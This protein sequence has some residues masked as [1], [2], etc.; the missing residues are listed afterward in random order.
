MSNQDL[1]IGNRY[2][3]DT[4]VD[5]MSLM[6]RGLG[7]EGTPDE[8]PKFKN[9]LDRPS[10][11]FPQRLPTTLGPVTR[12]FTGG[13][14]RPLDLGTLLYY[15]YGFS[16]VDV[17]A[18]NGWPYHR[19]VPSARCFY[20]T[21]LYVVTGDGVHHYDQLH[22]ALV[23]LRGGDHR[24]IV[25]RA[26]GAD[27]SGA[28]AVIVLT[29]HFWKT[30]FRYRHYAYRLC[31]Q[32]AG[33]VAGNVLMVA[34]A[35]GLTGHVHYQFLDAALDHLLGLV[36]GEERTVAVIPLYP[37]GSV[38]GARQEPV[39]AA[40][41][42]AALPEIRP[43]F[44]DVGKDTTLAG[45]VYLVDGHSVLDSAAE[46]G[47]PP[48]DRPRPSGG[49]PVALPPAGAEPDL[50]DALRRRHSGGSL[51][52]PRGESIP[53]SSLTRLARHL[54]QPYSAD[55]GGAPLGEV[56]LAVQR[57]EGLR[58]GVYRLNADGSGPCPVGPLP[59]G[60]LDASMMLGP[61][62]VDVP[63]VNVW[64]YVVTDRERV[65]GAWGNRGYRMAN[66]DAGVVAQR[67]CLLAG[68][69]GLAARPINGYVTADVQRL[70]GIGEAARTPIFQIALGRRT[71]TAQYEMP[72]VF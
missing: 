59:E 33:M 12:A 53:A 71:S 18:I 1:A 24:E 17:G 26:A 4:F 20:P 55:L 28:E 51:F 58:P 9:Y 13:P 70:L 66:M 27:L 35:L 46:F 41:L 40:E 39:T 11:P 61:P 31:T 29:S 34:A 8:P 65:T 21:E 43:P 60:R 30:A 37:A 64:C 10:R 44:T 72:V 56:Y 47:A 67:L 69:E 23:E 63:S 19:L 16:R 57:V 52:R 54:L 48:P 5:T 14:S 22:H 36:S 32:E 3:N 49:A 2:W 50:A 42:I 6:S 62:V 45:D 25:A 7:E 68:A 15:G 38:P